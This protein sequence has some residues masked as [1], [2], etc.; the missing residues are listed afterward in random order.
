MG[1][2][3]SEKEAKAKMAAAD[4]VL[5][6]H[7]PQMRAILKLDAFQLSGTKKNWSEKKKRKKEARSYLSLCRL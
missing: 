6:E 2:C 5:S 4:R 3:G 7:L 1:R